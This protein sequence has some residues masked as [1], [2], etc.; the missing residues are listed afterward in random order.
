M[1]FYTQ[2]EN[3]RNNTTLR[4]PKGDRFILQNYQKWFDFFLYIPIILSVVNGVALLALSLFFLVE[5]GPEIGVL[6]FLATPICIILT[7]V[8]SKLC[9]SYKILHIYY[10]KKIAN[11]T[12]RSETSLNACKSDDLPNI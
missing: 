3:N 4:P 6:L 9:T 1:N 11:G 5:E 2:E 10:L 7:Y 8:I 12:S